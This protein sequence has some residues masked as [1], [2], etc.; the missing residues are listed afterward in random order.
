MG[1]VSGLLGEQPMDFNF[2]RFHQTVLKRIA[3]GFY[4]GASYRLDRHY[5]I[6]DKKLDRTTSVELVN[7]THKKKK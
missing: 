1:D 5:A 7:P 6:V 4:A 2:V 3:N